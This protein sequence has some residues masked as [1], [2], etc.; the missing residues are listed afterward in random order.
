M[1]PDGMT[2]MHWRMLAFLC[3]G[4]GSFA[5]SS[6]CH[7]GGGYVGDK[8]LRK[9][10]KTAWTWEA[11]ANFIVLPFCSLYFINRK[12]WVT[13]AKASLNLSCC[14]CFLR[15][16]LCRSSISSWMAF[17]KLCSKLPQSLV[18]LKGLQ[19]IVCLLTSTA[20]PLDIFFSVY[21][22]IYLIYIHILYNCF[23][24]GDFCR[25]PRPEETK[26]WP[27]L[28]AL[29]SVWQVH[30]PISPLYPQL[31]VKLRIEFISLISPWQSWYV[32]REWRLVLACAK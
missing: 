10:W 22:Y 7:G 26:Q 12:C 17:S 19:H 14:G 24:F 30:Q 13:A 6:C 32:P 20:T 5:G 15:Y 3:P 28:H 23:S 9:R 25:V 16:Q 29:R 11:F 21:I 18:P 8:M 1:D 31:V 2:A 4:H 27:V